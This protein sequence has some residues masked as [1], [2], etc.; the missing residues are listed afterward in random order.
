[1]T[2]TPDF[3]NMTPEQIMAWMETL[4]K[5]Q[6]ASEGF[7]TSADAEVAEIDAS[8]VDQSV[9][10]QEYIPYGWKK[11]DWYA[12]LEK[13]KAQKQVKQASAPAPVQPP[14]PIPVPAPIPQPVAEPAPANDTPDF[15]K[16]SPEEIMAWMEKLA[17]RQGA[18]EGFTTSNSQREAV[19]AA[20]IDAST[21]DQS[22]LDQEYIP[23]G[24]KKEDWYAHLEKEK[25]QKQSKQA[26]PPAPQPIQEV[27]NDFDVLATPSLDDFFNTPSINDADLERIT[28]SLD[29]EETV[30]SVNPM[31]WLAGL[32]ND[33]DTDSLNLAS[34]GNELASLQTASP[35]SSGDPLDW[36]AGLAA[37]NE[38]PLDLAFGQDELVVEE[39]APVGTTGIDPMAWLE[40]LASSE[41]AD[42]AELIT[43]ANVPIERPATLATDGPGYRPYSFEEP[44]DIDP[45]PLAELFQDDAISVNDAEAWLDS[46]ASNV[47]QPRDMS[48]SVR[49]QSSEAEDPLAVIQALEKGGDV[50]PQDVASFF[51]KMF[52]RAEQSDEDTPLIAMDSPPIVAEIPDWLQAEMG[53]MPVVESAPVSDEAL[54]AQLGFT[55]DAV[56]DEGAFSAQFAIEDD[57]TEEADFLEED[58][59]ALPVAEMPAWLLE[60]LDGEEDETV[61]DIFAHEAPVQSATATAPK[62]NNF[63]IDESDPWVMALTTEVENE[64]ELQSWYE[65]QLN[66]IEPEN[67][68]NALQSAMFPIET[69][70]MNGRAQDVPMWLVGEELATSQQVVET[71]QIEVSELPDWLQETPVDDVPDWLNVSDSAGAGE[72]P[73]WLAGADVDI[74]AD[75]IPDWLRETVEEERTPETFF[76]EAVSKPVEPPKPQPTITAAPVVVQPAISPAPV[77]Q[78]ATK[79][80]VGGMLKTAREKL[81]V[82]IG[83]SL[84][85]YETVVLANTA[86]GEVVTDLTKALGDKTNKTNPAIYRVLG[87]ALMRQGNLQEALETYRKALNLL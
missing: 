45:I 87:D 4:A 6:G 23:Y 51:E 65:R 80:D 20:E 69:E 43:P 14:A 86:L 64:A 27:S 59:D 50:S 83:E 79:I 41:G 3:D 30:P 81:S 21:V 67:I 18:S 77:P 15:D 78:R 5:R 35:M 39:N 75:D 49:A 53:T 2:E 70:L 22:V 34:L 54:L 66:Q 73:D 26:T 17:E 58:D 9:L 68:P 71:P 74:S 55:E 8:T 1:M 19:K 48:D 60:D 13:E 62:P 37:P 7:T 31:D 36:L 61:A 57:A 33:A 32:A 29:E 24:W 11:E 38:S 84:K 63:Q 12:H 76:T 85:A 44:T 28:A 47:S 72:L 40:T 25:A 52:D 46:L 10:D 56:I 82:D 16:M 42:P